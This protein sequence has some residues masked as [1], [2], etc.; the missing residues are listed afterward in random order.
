ML[1]STATMA[2]SQALPEATAIPQGA[3]TGRAAQAQRLT[4]VQNLGDALP[5]HATF[6]DT[7]HRPV[8]LGRY[9]NDGRPVVMVLGYY[10]CPNLCGTVMQG[11]LEALAATGLPRDAWRI[12][13]VSVDP[14]ETPEIAAGQGRVWAQYAEFLDKNKANPHPLDLNPLVGDEAT[15]TAL[16]HTIGFTVEPDASAADPHHTAANTLSRYAHPAEFFIATPQGRISQYLMGVRFDAQD[17]RLALVA[18]SQ[19]SIGTLADRLVLLCSH[20]DP[21]TG[22]YN[23]AVMAVM[24]GVGI[25]SVLILVLWGWRHRRTPATKPTHKPA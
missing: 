22:R 13:Y 18:A 4:P 25:A 5:L 7:A 8:Q 6:A 14:A 2:F 11:V 19:G 24:R 9:F 17:L 10:R 15:T 3:I 12:V 16:A 21:T 1:I 20:F 23:G